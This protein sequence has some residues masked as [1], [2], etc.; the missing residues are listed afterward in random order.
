MSRL[1]VQVSFP[2]TLTAY[3][4]SPHGEL[5]TPSSPRMSFGF[6]DS[7]TF[8]KGVLGAITVF[9]F[10]QGK[11]KA[12]DDLALGLHPSNSYIPFTSM[13]PLTGGYKTFDLVVRDE[14][15]EGRQRFFL[16]FADKSE[17]ELLRSF[18]LFLL[19]PFNFF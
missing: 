5:P 17:L 11:P 10:H 19:T 15:L 16:D 4:S 13:V 14:I 1:D 9:T 3:F 7:G 18:V 2:F 6:F 8:P 12:G